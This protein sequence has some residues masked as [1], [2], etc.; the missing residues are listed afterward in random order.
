[1]LDEMIDPETANFQKYLLGLN[2]FGLYIGV[3]YEQKFSNSRDYMHFYDT[4]FFTSFKRAIVC[5]VC[6]LPCLLPKLLS[7]RGMT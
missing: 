3:I 7:K 2:I 5:M 6:G 1:M 4:D